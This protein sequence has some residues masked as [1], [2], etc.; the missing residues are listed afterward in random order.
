[1]G[2]ILRFLRSLATEPDRRV[3]APLYLQEVVCIAS[4]DAS[5]PRGCYR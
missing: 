2:G 5:S 1:M 3:L 4:Y